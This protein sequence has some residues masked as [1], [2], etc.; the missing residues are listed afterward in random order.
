MNTQMKCEVDESLTFIQNTVAFLLEEIVHDTG[1]ASPICF[2]TS[3]LGVSCKSRS[4]TQRTFVKMVIS[5]CLGHNIGFPRKENVT[6]C[7]H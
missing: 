1:R 5:E 3:P 7:A 6:N 4:G 2:V